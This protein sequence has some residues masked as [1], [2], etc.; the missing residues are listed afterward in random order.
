[1][2]LNNFTML[3]TIVREGGSRGGRKKRGEGGLE[4]REAGREGRMGGRRGEKEG[5]KRRKEGR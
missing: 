1:M 5:G 3:M 4:K 2:L